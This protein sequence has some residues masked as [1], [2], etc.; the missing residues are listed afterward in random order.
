MMFGRA[1]R[2]RAGPDV[3]AQLNLPELQHGELD[4]SRRESGSALCLTH[5][6]S[7][8]PDTFLLYGCPRAHCRHGLGPGS[9]ELTPGYLETV[10]GKGRWQHHGQRLVSW[11]S[12][13]P[14]PQPGS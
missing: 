9:S 2:H 1:N 13:V 8:A 3:W 4:V 6:S 5:L 14:D 7:T 12:S 10:L 11:A